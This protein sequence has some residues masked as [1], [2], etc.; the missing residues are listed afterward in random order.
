MV[1]LSVQSLYRP[2][3][4]SVTNP[5]VTSRTTSRSCWRNFRVGK[6]IWNL[7][8]SEV[9]LSPT[10]MMT[11]ALSQGSRTVNLILIVL[12]RLVCLWVTQS[13]RTSK[14]QN[15]SHVLQLRVRVCQSHPAA[16]LHLSMVVRGEARGWA[17][18]IFGRRRDTAETPA[19]KR[20]RELEKFRVRMNRYDLYAQKSRES[21]IWFRTDERH[22]GRIV[23]ENVE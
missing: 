13:Q 20:S 1:W 12:V 10:R 15:L 9:N 23:L 3:V 22:D 18:P 2:Q 5:P 21:R 6:K 11:L 14:D 4:Q 19:C 8:L 17:L 7:R 16:N